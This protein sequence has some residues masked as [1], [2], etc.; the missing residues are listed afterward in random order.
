MVKIILSST[1]QLKKLDLVYYNNIS[2]ES[3][4]IRIILNYNYRGYHELVKR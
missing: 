3:I 2:I 4:H 1:E